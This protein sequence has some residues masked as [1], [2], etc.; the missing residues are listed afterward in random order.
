MN[1]QENYFLHSFFLNN[2]KKKLTNQL[3]VWIRDAFYSLGLGL[4][5]F[6]LIKLIVKTGSGDPEPSLSYTA[7]G[8]GC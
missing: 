6:F 1:K 5:L 7:V 8:L 3:Q 4:E 2:L